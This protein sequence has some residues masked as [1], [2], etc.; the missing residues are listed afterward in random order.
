MQPLKWTTYEV[1]VLHFV[2][3][4]MSVLIF[5]GLILKHLFAFHHLEKK[6]FLRKKI[7]PVCKTLKCPVPQLILIRVIQNGNYLSLIYK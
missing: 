4:N 3:Q 1:S 6:I 7:L 2:L 5:S